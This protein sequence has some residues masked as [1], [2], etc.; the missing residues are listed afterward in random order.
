MLSFTPLAGLELPIGFREADFVVIHP[1][2]RILVIEVKSGVI[3]YKNGLWTQTNTITGFTK[4][5]SP[6]AQANKSKFE[7][8]ERLNSELRLGRTPLVC[9]A[10]W[11]P[12]FPLKTTDRLPPEAPKEIVLDETALY[13][14]QIKIDDIFSYWRK[15]TGINTS[16]Y[17]RQ[18]NEVIDVLAPTFRAIPGMKNVINETDKYCIRLTNQQ[19]A[20][21]LEWLWRNK[22]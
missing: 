3:D 14:V 6:F 13:D 22:K 7:I 2:K 4:I 19:A 20:S 1:E 5:I 18:L 9:H 12:S 21:N 16:M 15:K 10:V 17:P 11:F 8:I